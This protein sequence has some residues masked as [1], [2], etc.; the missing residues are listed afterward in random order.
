MADTEGRIGRVGTFVRGHA[1]EPNSKI[2]LL[3]Q[4][5]SEANLVTTIGA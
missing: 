5:L 3:R 2:A 1:V 4:G